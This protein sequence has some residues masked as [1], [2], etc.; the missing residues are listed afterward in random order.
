[1]NQ[2]CNDNMVSTNRGCLRV[3]GT[4]RIGSYLNTG[5]AEK[6]SIES[7]YHFTLVFKDT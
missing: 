3:M 5:T 1:M 2:V 4:H 6:D 7:I